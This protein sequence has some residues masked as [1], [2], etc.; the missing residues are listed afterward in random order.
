[1]MDTTLDGLESTNAFLDDIIIITKGTIEKHEAEI[2]KTLHRLNEENLAIS[3]HKW[4][5]GLNEITWLGYK[6]NSEGIKPTKRKTDAIIQLE[7]PKTLKQLR[8]IMGSIH[9]LIKFIPNLA[10]LSAPIRP[11]LSSATSKKKLEWNENHSIAFQNIKNAIQKIVE[12]K[13]F[14][15]QKDTRVKCD[16]SKEGRGACLEQKENNNWQPIAYASRFLNKNE[17]RYSINE[18]ELLAVVWSLEHFKYY[19]FGS[20]FTLQT[21]HQA[22]LSALKKNRGNKTYQSRLTRW[23]DR[24]LPFHFKVEHIS[25]K[26]MGFADYL[27]RHPNSP[28]TGENMN[29]NHVINVITSLK[30][31]L[32]SNQRKLTNQRARAI[33]TQND[34]INHSKRNAQKQHA[35]CQFNDRNQSPLITPYLSNKF[36]FNNTLK[37]KLLLSKQNTHTSPPSK[38]Y[39]TTRGRPDRETNNIPITKRPRL[40]NKKRMELPTGDPAN[41]K[42]TIATQTEETN[43]LGLGRT[44]LNSKQHYNPFS[45]INYDEAPDYLKNLHQVLG[46]DFIAEAT[47]ADPQSRSLQQIIKDKDWTTLKHFSR[48]W[49]SLKRDLGVTPS[50]CIIYDGKLFIPTQLRK[51]I[52]NSIHRKHPGQSGMMH[53]ANLIW[54]P[55]IHRE[56]VTLTQNCQPCIKI[57]K[58]IKPII[59]K[60]KISELPKLSEPNEEVQMDFAGP[61]LDEKNKESYILASVDR[62][63][64]Y[65]HAKV[66]HN[67]DAETAIDHLNQYIKFHGIPRNIRCDQAQSF[68]SRQFEIYCKNNNIKLILA[69]VGDHRATGMIER[70]IQTIKRRLSVL[71]NDTNLSK[72]TL[73]DKIAEIIQEIKI[74][75]NTTTKIAPYT[76]HFGRKINTQLSNI[77]TK[78]SHTNLSYKNTKKFLFRQEEGPQATHAE[79]GIHMECRDRLGARI[80]H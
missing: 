53:L 60:N 33:N 47:K 20:H 7:N 62:Y 14:N 44:P 48:Y 28:P 4:E 65:P 40:P 29:E 37:N 77:V 50:G 10:T 59:P 2:D 27:S 67:C 58:N 21:D 23:V 17:Q 36:P 71:N 22:L 42:N 9:H 57:G 52:R 46:E 11:L 3:L 45:E 24:L 54:F 8:S 69:P 6:I 13:H 55:R 15:I 79:P 66:Y 74:I 75:P 26:N 72:I 12:Q 73:A 43:N 56:I 35:F 34:V 38:I 39:I 41:I 16:A 32:A 64:R 5:F 63:S 76:A 1:M 61:V 70:L 18:L 30:Y 68:K 25:G 19:L 78:P 31:I 80:G 49:H 51:P